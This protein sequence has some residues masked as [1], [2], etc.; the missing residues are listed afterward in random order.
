MTDP[1]FDDRRAAP[2]LGSVPGE[3]LPSRPAQVA[4]SDSDYVVPLS[5]A[6][7]SDDAPDAV[8]AP[9]PLP[10]SRGCYFGYPSGSTPL[11]G[12][13]IKRGIGVGG[14][15]EVYF[16][17]SD[18][19]KE[20]ALKR[21]LRNV[22]IEL[23]GVKQC[24]N[25]KHVHLVSLFDIRQDA[26]GQVWVVMEHVA[27][28]CLKDKLDRNPHGLPHDEVNFWTLGIGLGTAYLHDRGI[29]H[30]DLKPGNIFLDEG[31]VKIGDYG[32][33]KFIA[34][35]QRVDQ[36]QSVGTF[37][38]M[39]P[40]I[41]KGEY[42]REVDIYALGVMLFEMTTGT[43]PFLGETSQEIALKHLTATADLSP[44]PERYRSTV[45]RCLR[46]DPAERFG[47]VEE[48]LDSLD[49]PS[50]PGVAAFS[51]IRR[52]DTEEGDDRPTDRAE[53]P[54]P[55]EPSLGRPSRA[56]EILLEVDDGIA[57]G[58]VREAPEK[59]TADAEP[60]IRRDRHPGNPFRDGWSSLGEFPQPSS[61]A[62][63]SLLKSAPASLVPAP[64]SLVIERHDPQEPIAA[65]VRKQWRR[66]ADW[67]ISSRMSAPAKV[68][69]LIAAVTVVLLNS[70]W[71]LPLLVCVGIVYFP[72][73]A[74]RA[75]WLAVSGN[76]DRLDVRE[77]ASEPPL[78]E[79][80]SVI[81]AKAPAN[82]PVTARRSSRSVD[83]KG[84]EKI[85][86]G[87]LP[88]EKRPS[89]KP[90][91]KKEA[92][93]SFGAWTL[94]SLGFAAQSQ[95]RSVRQH[96]ERLPAS[97]RATELFASLLMASA[98]VASL[99]LLALAV[100]GRATIRDV[101]TAAFYLWLT[102]TAGFASWTLVSLGKHWETRPEEPMVRRIA[103]A[104]VGTAT[105]AVSF[106][107]ATYLDV[108]LTDE[109]RATLMPAILG[110][111]TP[112]VGAN[113]FGISSFLAF[114]CGAFLVPHWWRQVD[115]QRKTRLA[116]MSVIGCILWAALLHLLVP[117]A[118]PWGLLAVGIVAI[119]VQLSAPWISPAARTRIR[120]KAKTAI[121]R[122]HPAV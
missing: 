97:A 95:S 14:F 119:A 83:G 51:W 12:Y 4:I 98:V 102:I 59:A 120:A 42:G 60:A 15:G 23:R 7:R 64:A 41:S 73:Y 70:Q 104:L 67:W 31:V 18:A 116:L 32:L 34:R 74:G 49:L 91:P 63:A 87:K 10:T 2:D 19:G 84:A 40:E 48:L 17:V 85:A 33:S 46:K 27:G 38:Y 108:P 53:P 86:E 55:I 62:A 82:S 117:F 69:L 35:S 37:H 28:E 11:E 118:Q 56:A 52:R 54:I 22:D 65:A 80:F 66:L 24:L 121:L 29:V 75:V 113:A 71:L 105:G 114:F 50:G 111:T 5:R 20:V 112:G 21:I 58:D 106:A 76:Y 16:A 47:R 57:F 44:V 79:G 8:P 72:Y 90:A 3:A 109:L 68:L 77:D 25:L 81:E 13:T 9:T 89:D 100:G 122:R 93:K 30:R 92:A 107:T 78:G 94:V 36:T 61:Q 1:A 110:E 115:P 99:S 103:S 43:L 101:D 6:R 96:L 88:P 26:H 39:A 45:E